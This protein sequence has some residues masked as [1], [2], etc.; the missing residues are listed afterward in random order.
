MLKVDWRKFYGEEIKPIPMEKYYLDDGCSLEIRQMTYEFADTEVDGMYPTFEVNDIVVDEYGRGN[1][2]LVI[3]CDRGL[4][5]LRV[6]PL[7]EKMR[8]TGQTTY[9]DEN[10]VFHKVKDVEWI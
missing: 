6:E 10:E 9:L 8:K 1:S 5:E 4:Q 7:D 3:D 2:F